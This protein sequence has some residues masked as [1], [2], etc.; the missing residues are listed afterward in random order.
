[1][2]KIILIKLDK[3]I[4][5]IIKGV[6]F[7]LPLF[8]LPW[9]S[10]YF[11]FNKQFLFWLATGLALFL[12]LIKQAV[13]GAIKIKINP[14]NL[15][16]IIFLALT[17]VSAFFS[18]D[19][20][21]S[22]FGSYGR[23][24]DAWLGLLSLAI[25][26]FLLINTG[27]AAS[28]KKIFVL[29]KLLFYAAF[30]LA[31]I[32]LLAMSGLIQLLMVGQFNVL[33]SPS[34][35]PAGGSL[36]SLAI[37]LAVMSVAAVGF[38]SAGSLK[39]LDRFIF[40]AGLILFLTVLALINFYLSWII[41]VLGVGLLLSGH[42]L[43]TGFS[44]KKIL[45]YYWLI[46]LAVMLVAI[47]MLAPLKINPAKIILGRVLPKEVLLDYKTSV[48]IT[49]K[50]LL[51]K[52]I[53]G[54]G[55]A[56]F[57]NDFSL[58]R[59]AEFN[60][61]DYWQVR[62]DKSS[63]QFLEI[64]A[65]LGLPAWL[66]Y[67]LIISLVIYINI[68]LFIKYLKNRE[69]LLTD[70]NYNL[71]TIVFTAFI[72][73][74]AAQ[75]FFPVNTVLNFSFWFFAA[76]AI[77][78]WQNYNQ[79][80]FKEKTV[81]LNKIIL[82]SRL[83]LLSLFFLGAFCLTL[84]AFEIKFFAAELAAVSGSNR[85][86]GLLLA[87]KLNP[88]RVNYNINLA[89]FYLDRARFE[90]AKPAGKKE[91]DFIQLNISRAIRAGRL[92]VAAAPASVQAHETLGMIYRDIRPLTIGSELWAAQFFESALALEPT[93]PILAAE[94]AK[95]YLNNND[96]ANAE[97]YFI[98]A[99]ELKPEYYEA[100]FGLA[101]V[102]L[103]NKKDDLALNLLNELAAKV[104]DQEIF[105]ELGRFYYNHGEINKAIDRFK[106]ALSLAP[107][108]AN[109]L[110]SLGTAYEAKGDIKQALKYY[111]QVLELNQRN[112]DIKKKIEALN[113]VK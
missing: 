100:K 19:V 84:A 110:Y 105:Y 47:L 63:S 41:L 2:S 102:Y 28:A 69:P 61:N 54:S 93:N 107:K 113:N 31:V 74:L 111:S 11:E 35:N 101:K 1:M 36:L 27:L 25:F 6:V 50:A 38:L 20:F 23:F 59:P 7:L 5:I 89:E 80:L 44:F 75:L 17:A 83:S 46:P 57:S 72:L 32:S 88:A 90:A 86:A 65:T 18:L 24:S 91:N 42:W 60:K 109:S 81:E 97:K 53:F 10:E 78:F 45:N 52:P 21:S 39:R 3:L 29:L 92:A 62:F 82:F 71:I 68:I 56:T 4:A 70:E 66:S 22:F 43:E 106:L 64:L 73:L 77:A 98:R 51:A 94:L 99:S 14:L 58:Y 104:Y 103:R 9:T 40:G 108:H 87:V 37:F 8:F 112:N 33:V 12:W 30:I 79:F 49:K 85:E 76:L 67:F 55:P 16:I 96:M 95:A 48:L 34:F 26:Y 13:A 15:P